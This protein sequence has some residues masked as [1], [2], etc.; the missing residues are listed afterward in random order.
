MGNS[1]LNLGTVLSQGQNEAHS[2][3]VWLRQIDE[4][5]IY[6]GYDLKGPRDTWEYRVTV[7][8]QGA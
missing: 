1:N 3:M 6:C 7:S 2:L 5:Y 8:G 4:L